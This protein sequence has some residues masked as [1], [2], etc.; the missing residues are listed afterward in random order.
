VN[1]YVLKGIVTYYDDQDLKNVF[2]YI[3][4]DVSFVV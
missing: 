2:D 1:E 4:E 3:Q